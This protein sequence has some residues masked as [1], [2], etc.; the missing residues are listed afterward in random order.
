MSH[1]E[2]VPLP[3]VIHDNPNP[4]KNDIILHCVQL[5]AGGNHLLEDA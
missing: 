2:A 4:L 5:I 1:K 3:T